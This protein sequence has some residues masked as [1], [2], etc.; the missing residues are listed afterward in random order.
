[1]ISGCATRCRDS[2]CE[3][4]AA[5]N[6]SA[7]A[8]QEILFFNCLWSNIVY[9]T[10]GPGMKSFGRSHPTCL[11]E[12]SASD[13]FDVSFIHLKHHR[14]HDQIDREHQAEAFFAADHDSFRTHERPALEADFRALVQVGMRLQPQTC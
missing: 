6:K 7:Q 5:Q 4:A 12:R 14:S 11:A 1:M 9:L 2:C 10:P 3:Y 8:R 13:R